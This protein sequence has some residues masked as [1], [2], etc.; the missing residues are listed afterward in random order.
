MNDARRD[1]FH[2]K[3]LPLLDELYGAALRMARNPQAAEDLVSET[4][5]KAW[6]NLAQFRTGTNMRA[7][8]YRIL[9]NLYINGYR[10]K[11]REPEKISVDAYDKA[12]DFHLFNRLAAH[13]GGASPDPMK[14]VINRLTDEDFRKALNA[15]PEEY[16]TTVVLYD[17]QGL[18]YQEAAGALKVPVGTV[19]SR[20]SRGRKILQKSLWRHARDSGLIEPLVAQRGRA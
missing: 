13:A 20:L 11:R 12:D 7:W 15:L 16:R 17:L 1:E 6:K 19:R 5:V 9:T 8:L 10:K 3:A 14:T 18:S 2:K 4:Y